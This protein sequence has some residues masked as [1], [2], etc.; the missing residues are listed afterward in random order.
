VH[1]AAVSLQPSRTAPRPYP[2]LYSK[3]TSSAAAT[4][5]GV[6]SRSPSCCSWLFSTSKLS[7]PGT[8]R[9]YST[10]LN[11]SRE[12]VDLEFIKLLGPSSLHLHPN[13]TLLFLAKNPADSESSL[14]VKLVAP[15]CCG[16]T[17]H[18]TLAVRGFAPLLYG[19]ACV[20]GA[21]SAIVMEYLDAN[22]GWMTLQNYIKE[23]QEITINTEHPRLA[24]LLET[25]KTERVVHGDLRPNNIMCRE[26]PGK[27]KERGELEIKVIDFDWA[28][29][30]GVARY[31]TNRNPDIAWPGNQRD[32]IGE[33]DDKELLS[34]TLAKLYS[35]ID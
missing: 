25:M 21:P 26:L 22:S 18:R 20:V 7:P 31:P 5:V 3:G 19:T 33:D 32:L 8:P 34:K 10:Y 16:E 4:Q 23:N 29:K 9:V 14:L 6:V 12:N 17:V 11:S 13:P 30:L 27:G 2:F 1:D 28:G 24:E 15:E 35:C